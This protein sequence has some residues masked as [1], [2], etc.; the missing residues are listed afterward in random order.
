MISFRP[1]ACL[2]MTGLV[3][4]AAAAN[5]VQGSSLCERGQRQ[6]PIDITTT[7]RRALPPLAASYRAVPLRAVNDGHTV[8]LRFSGAGGL[9][10]GRERL[11]LQQ[12]HFHTPGG[13]R[14]AGEDFPMALHLL[15]R[16]RAGQL[17]PVVVLYRLGAESAALA[18][19]LDHLPGQP[20][21][22]R[23]RPDVSVDPARL[24][25]PRLG[26][27]TY[28]GSVTDVPCT[29]GVRWIVLK[30][31]MTL[32]A[33]QLARLQRLFAPNAR[34]VQP[35]NGRVVGESP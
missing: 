8:R 30:T 11:T 9:D 26:Y 18:E 12:I 25:P 7:Q 2:L 6:S 24:L 19:L 28:D 14:I 4:C 27:Y 20:G 35:L 1:I 31:P 33:P 22:E 10:E 13:D 32:S 34:A 29:E 15:H 17:V 21:Q 23:A 5:P 3:A 16:S